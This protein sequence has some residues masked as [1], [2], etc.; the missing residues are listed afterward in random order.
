MAAAA[1]MPLPSNPPLS[2]PSLLSTTEAAKLKG[3]TRQ[4]IADALRRGALQGS[5]LGRVWYVVRDTTFEAY[6]VRETGGRLHDGY[7]ARHQ[8]TRRE[9][10][11]RQRDRFVEE[12]RQDN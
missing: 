7:L 11:R 12:Q 4:T 2:F 5:K 1:L 3:C 8:R 6:E 9:M 10:Q